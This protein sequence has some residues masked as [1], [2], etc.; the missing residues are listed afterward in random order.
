[1]VFAND[2]RYSTK[3]G[4]VKPGNYKIGHRSKYVWST[5]ANSPMPW[6][7]FWGDNEAIHYSPIFHKYGYDC[8]SFGC[9]GIW[10]KA[11]AKKL[12]HLTPKGTL[13]KLVK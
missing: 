8:G 5:V 7:L 10:S 9:V 1:M 2:A 4:S 3:W 11:H 6:S 12:Y 13:F